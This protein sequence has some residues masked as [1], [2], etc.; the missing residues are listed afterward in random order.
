MDPMVCP[1][2]N[3]LDKRP[4][5]KNEKHNNHKRHSKND[6]LLI[7]NPIFKSYFIKPKNFTNK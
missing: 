4:I 1:M 7:F 5:R 2:G 6:K 3:N